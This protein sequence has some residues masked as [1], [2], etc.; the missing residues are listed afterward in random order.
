MAGKSAVV[1]VRLS[2][3]EQESLA[4]LEIEGASTVSD[5][6]RMLVA[7]AASERHARQEFAAAL[8][9]MNGLL[10]PVKDGIKIAE[11]RSGMRSEWMDRLLN[12]LPSAVAMVLSRSGEVSNSEPQQLVEL[13]RELLE[14]HAR[15][16][17]SVFQIGLSPERGC[18]K[19]ENYDENV[20]ACMAVAAAVSQAL[21]K[22]EQ[23]EVR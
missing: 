16:M 5:K 18:Y 1:T 3:K 19:R 11:H 17:T 15:F 20:I 12:W 8:N 10:V 6:I 23:G 4:L 7:R 13:E 9:V 2:A 21:D 14:E 22:Q